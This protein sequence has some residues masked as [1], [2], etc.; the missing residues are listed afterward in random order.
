VSQN[1]SA[2]ANTIHVST[3]EIRSDRRE[4]HQLAKQQTTPGQKKIY[5]SLIYD[6]LRAKLKKPSSLEDILDWIRINHPAKHQE[7]G[8]KK[9]RTSII[10]S[11]NFQA[12]KLESKRTIWLYSRKNSIDKWQ[13]HKPVVAVT[14]VEENMDTYT[15]RHART[16]SRLVHPS[17]EG[18]IRDG[19]LESCE[20]TSPPE[21]RQTHER[22][23][24]SGQET[25]PVIV[26]Q[27]RAESRL[28]FTES[29]PSHPF[30]E[31]DAQTER[32]NLASNKA[33]PNE[34]TAA[35]HSSNDN[36]TLT[37]TE[38]AAGSISATSNN[39]PSDT[40]ENRGPANS[41]DDPGQ[42]CKDEPDLGKI[43]LDLRRLKQERM[44]REQKIEADRNDLP[45]ISTL[46]Q[47]ANDAQRAAGEAQRAADEAQRI[48]DEAQRAAETAKESVED[49]EARHDQFAADKLDLEKLTRDSNFL[50]AKLGID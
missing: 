28:A 13:L 2:S 39:E 22:Y 8:E 36:E 41:C 44:L 16:P 6:A 47:T 40:V 24:A 10:T 11:L 23:Y 48:A 27:V 15:E 14:D 45:D 43:V 49:A 21:L 20:D 38:P 25:S 30:S 3:P 9:L 35:D 46:T 12:R 18:Q 32:E 42:N 34:M 29:Q 7:Y 19:A 33:V 4:S 26:P 1:T 5:L 37:Q 50:R 31:A 17:T